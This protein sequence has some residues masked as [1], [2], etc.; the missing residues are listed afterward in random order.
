MGR[1]ARTQF[2]SAFMS[3][4]KWRKLFA[5]VRDAGAGVHE[6]TVKF[7]DVHEPCRMRFPPS[8]ACP[9]AY[10]DVLTSIRL[11]SALPSCGRSNGW[12]SQLN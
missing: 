12:N 1:L 9:R 6:M 4:S 8:L 10:I 3:D 11:N 5:A 2:L 7:I